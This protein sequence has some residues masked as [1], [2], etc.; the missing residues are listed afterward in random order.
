MSDRNWLCM[1][2]GK[3]TF[4]SP[5][6]Y[7]ML[8]NRLWRILVPK[9]QRHGML[10]L[11][12]IEER[13]GRPLIPNDFQSSHDDESDPED[14]PMSRADYGIIDSLTSETLQ[15]IDA[16]LLSFA[17]SSPRSVGAIVAKLM[18]SQTA[19]PGLPDWFYVERVEQ[20]IDCGSLTIIE[21]R[22]LLLQCK[23]QAS[24]V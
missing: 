22:D 12:C 2:C 16:A 23:V 20:L 11:A 15:D 9:N 17:A 7:Y 19:V 18:E 14:A 13:L 8:R 1:D 21:E 6:D 4:N 5:S 24:S 10:C 3:S